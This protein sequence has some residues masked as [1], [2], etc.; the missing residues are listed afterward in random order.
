MLALIVLERDEPQTA[1]RLDWLG[2]A[3]LSPGLTLL[4]FGLAESSSGGFGESKSWAPIVAGAVLIAG[5]FW[6]SW[7]AGRR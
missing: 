4:I 7:R 5:F 6:H 2:M 1:H 3:L